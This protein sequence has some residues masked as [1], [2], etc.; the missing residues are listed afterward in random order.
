M[1][2]SPIWVLSGCLNNNS[3]CNSAAH[4][5]HSCWCCDLCSLWHSTLQYRTRSQAEHSFNLI[6]SPS[7]MPQDA[8]HDVSSLLHLHS[9]GILYCSCIIII[10]LAPSRRDGHYAS[11]AITRYEIVYNISTLF[12]SVGCWLL[13]T[14]LCVVF[15]VML[16]TRKVRPDTSFHHIIQACS[17]KSKTSM[18]WQAQARQEACCSFTMRRKLPAIILYYIINKCRR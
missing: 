17:A 11:V 13:G 1:G 6:S 14:Q 9:S 15:L 16:L 12:F 5:L 3:S 4:F 10:I 7:A 18:M 8:Q 2:Q